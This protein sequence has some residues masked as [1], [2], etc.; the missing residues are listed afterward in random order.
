MPLSGKDVEAAFVETA[1]EQLSGEPFDWERCARHL[2]ARQGRGARFM[3][4]HGDPHPE[5]SN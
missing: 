5:Q 1:R 4:T 2:N 3:L